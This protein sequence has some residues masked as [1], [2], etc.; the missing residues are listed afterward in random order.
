MFMS[1]ATYTSPTE[2]AYYANHSTETL[3]SIVA[4]AAADGMWIAA[5]H[6]AD[7]PMALAKLEIWVAATGALLLRQA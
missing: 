6:G 7:H 4:Q 5:N 2:S 3:E 1:T